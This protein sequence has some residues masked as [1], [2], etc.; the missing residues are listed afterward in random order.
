MCREDRRRGK[1]SAAICREVLREIPLKKYSELTV[2][3]VCR[4][5][6]I[7]RR[8]FYLHFSTME[9]VYKQIFE[10]INAPLYAGFE[11]LKKKQAEKNEKKSDDVEMVREIFNLINDTIIR[12]QEY[13]A[14]LAAEPSYSGIQTMHINLLKDMIREYMVSTGME[15]HMRKVYLD[16]YVAGVL[17]LYFQWY[18]GD[19]S[20]TL[21]EIRDFACR[22]IREDMRIWRG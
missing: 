22:I 7:S 10:D 2:S 6:D 1:T 14:R 3:G 19:S 12:N 20:M 9:D 21:E 5:L 18:R 8:T 17:E 15:E 11:E 4:D 16:Y 13:L